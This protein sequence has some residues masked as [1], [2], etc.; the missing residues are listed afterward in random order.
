MNNALH[1]FVTWSTRC[2]IRQLHDGV[3][4]LKSHFL[5]TLERFVVYLIFAGRQERCFRLVVCAL[6]TSCGCEVH[7]AV[8]S[9]SSMS[10][11]VIWPSMCRH[12]GVSTACRTS[13]P[14]SRPSMSLSTPLKSS[15][16]APGFMIHRQSCEWLALM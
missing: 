13:L 14:R 16:H 10:L 5:R 7:D 1:V 4:L 2:Y 11:G 9:Y 6:E 8:V 3:E 15:M 12:I